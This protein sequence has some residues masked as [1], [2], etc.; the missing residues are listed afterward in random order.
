MRESM[1]SEGVSRRGFVKGLAI[2]GAGMLGMGLLGCAP[3]TASA[4]ATGIPETW[5]YEADIVI[6]GFGGAGGAAAAKAAELGAQVI[7][8][9]K[10]TEELAGGDTYCFGGGFF[11]PTGM[12]A[13]YYNA[14]GTMTEETANEI[15]AKASE[16]Y[17]WMSGSGLVYRENGY[18]V[19]GGAPAFYEVLRQNVLAAGAQV[20][21]ETPGVSLIQ[22]PVTKEIK[23]VNAL[24]GDKAITVK[25]KK[26]VIIATGD[27]VANHELCEALHWRQLKW[28]T[29]GTPAATGEGGLMALAVGAKLE[30]A[31]NNCWEWASV[32][33]RAASEEIGTAVLYTQASLEQIMA[34]AE[35]SSGVESKIFV[36]AAGKR[37]MDETTSLN[38]QKTTTDLPFLNLYAPLMDPNK[39]YVNLPMFL[40]IDDTCFKAAPLGKSIGINNPVCWA[41][42]K[43]IYTWSD[44][45]VAELDRGWILKADTIEELA[46]KMTSTTYMAGTSVTVPAD[47]LKQTIDEYNAGCAAGQ[48]AFGRQ[49]PQPIMTPPFYAVEVMPATVYTLGFLQAD[50]KSRV[51]SV[52]NQPIPRLYGAGNVGQG[53]E[54]MP[55]GVCGTMGRGYMA[56]YDAAALT[57]W[58]AAAEE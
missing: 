53:T 24:Q 51:I 27:Y 29:A 47:A 2:G 23:G 45:N 6:L 42:C 22:D 15:F 20:L 38:H 1:G 40:V 55:I 50:E 10:M 52:E 13:Y 14:N 56:A 46:A 9:E 36:N 8:L 18:E 28:A 35:G 48:D 58:D 5:D 7:I 32:A 37:F 19:E 3:D 33:L 34:N 43:G 26:G 25:A 57:A 54:M 44:D 11:A 30:H 4:A 39:E 17:E 31:N 12:E 41:Q 16:V 21:Y 49:V